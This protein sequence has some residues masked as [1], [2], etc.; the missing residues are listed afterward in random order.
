MPPSLLCHPAP[1]AHKHAL[2]NTHMSLHMELRLQL[3]E[4]LPSLQSLNVDL[5]RTLL[6]LLC[7]GI[8]ALE[9]GDKFEYIPESKNAKLPIS[10][11]SNIKT[12]IL[13]QGN[14]LPEGG[15]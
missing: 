3:R 5:G 12:P 15:F 11:Q 4:G 2:L 9:A 14:S 8:T 10:G 13:R 7:I 1:H 6:L